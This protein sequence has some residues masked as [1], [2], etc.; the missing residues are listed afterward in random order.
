MCIEEPQR[1]ATSLA[2]A[3]LAV[4][5]LGVPVEAA[6][7][8][9][10]LPEAQTIDLAALVK[11]RQE[12]AGRHPVAKRISRYLAAAAE[13]VDAGNPEEA[14]ELLKKLYMNRLNPYERALVYRLLAFVA[15][16]ANDSREAI[17]YFEKFLEQEMLPIRDEARVRFN[18]A[19]LYASLEEWRQMIRWLNIWLLYVEDPDPIGF[20]LLGIAHYQLEDFEAAIVQTKK[21]VEAGPEPREA[22][23]RLLAALYSQGQDYENVGPV[24]EELILRF[25]KK[26]YWVQLSLIYGAR[27]DYR[28]SLAAQQVA[29]AQGFL[30]ED[31]ELRRLARSYLYHE[32]PFPAATVLEK[33]LEGSV[34]DADADAFELLANSWIAAREYERSLEPLQKAAELSEDGNLYVR[35]GQV[36]MQREVWDEASAL[37]EKAVGKG[38]LK[39]PGNAQLLLGIA[40]YNTER[41]APARSAFLRARKHDKTE[42]AAE[43]WIEHL[44]R[45]SEASDETLSPAG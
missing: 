1:A 14:T 18:I 15:Y 22:W 19:Q 34:I 5:F 41:V 43:R 35:L 9:E 24:L 44:D 3:L 7:S 36:H 28:R 20:Y 12:K 30:T 45:E 8:D 25:P 27:D 13:A 6:A 11:D 23:L 39:D 21:A 37:L 10:A 38:G 26:Q 29:Y 42:V 16:S 31:K 40:Y 32:L 4:W 2:T 33:G 17:R